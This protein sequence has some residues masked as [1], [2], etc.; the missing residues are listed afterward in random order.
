MET[1]REY[2][3]YYIG[4]KFRYNY[5]DSK[6]FCVWM[7]ITPYRLSKLDDASIDT[8]Q[9]ALKRLKDLTEEEAEQLLRLQWPG[10]KDGEIKNIE[11]TS[12]HGVRGLWW[13]NVYQDWHKLI[14]LFSNIN[15]AQFHFLLSRGYWL[16]DE[17]AFDKGLIIDA[18]TL[19]V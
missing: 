6:A 11:V 7:D 3:H 2:I 17:S 14:T 10:Y 19:Q 18:K 9:I 16:W 8:I 5:V 13:S 1:I 12:D 4:Q 15:S